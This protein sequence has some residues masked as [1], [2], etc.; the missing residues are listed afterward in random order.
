MAIITF[1][2]LIIPTG[3][4]TATV[5]R[6]IR[7]CSI[8][9]RALRPTLT[10]GIPISHHFGQIIAGFRLT[11][12]TIHKKCEYIALQA[13][14]SELDLLRQRITELEVELKAGHEEWSIGASLYMEKIDVL[15]KDGYAELKVR[16]A[17]LEQASPSVDERPQNERKQEVSPSAGAEDDS[18]TS[19]ASVTSHERVKEKNE[20]MKGTDKLKQ[21][22]F[23]RPSEI[24]NLSKKKQNHVGEMSETP[25]PRN[26]SIDEA[27]QHLAYMYDKAIDA[28]D[29]AMKT[30]QGIDFDLDEEIMDDKPVDSNHPTNVQSEGISVQTIS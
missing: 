22:L 17:K 25:R 21:E 27:S 2:Y 16:V 24:E 28:E 18:E 26:P 23:N 30:N 6:L 19:S 14:P 8:F 11:I 20:H 13:N 1:T 7:K 4:F 29:T 15:K 9:L 12:L 10:Q 3:R 5:A